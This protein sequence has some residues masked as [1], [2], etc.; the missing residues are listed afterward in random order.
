MGGIDVKNGMVLEERK[1]E[2]KFRKA[3]IIES[4]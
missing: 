1:L 4:I 2:L 3:I